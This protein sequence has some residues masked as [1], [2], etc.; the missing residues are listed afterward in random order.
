LKCDKCGYVSFDH[1]LTCPSCNRDMSVV[2][3]RLHLFFEPPEV[4]FDQYFVQES[5]HYQTASS[6]PAME[7][8]AE[9]DLDT[10]DDDFE[11]T[12]DD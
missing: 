9:L 7:D 1:N 2:R 3:N 11:F 10:A 5:G 8:E 6:A 4:D 12:L